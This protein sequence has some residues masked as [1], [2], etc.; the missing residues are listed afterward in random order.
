MLITEDVLF[1]FVGRSAH[2]PALNIPW[3]QI[4][5]TSK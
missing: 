1:E 4:S 2:V 3:Q 5:A